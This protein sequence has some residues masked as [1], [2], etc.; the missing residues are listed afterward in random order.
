MLVCVCAGLKSL[1]YANHVSTHELPFDFTFMCSLNQIFKGT[2]VQQFNQSKRVTL[3]VIFPIVSEEMYP[4]SSDQIFFI[5]HFHM[6]HKSNPNSL[7]VQLCYNSSKHRDVPP[8]SLC[9]CNELS[10][11]PFS[12]TTLS[13]LGSRRCWI[14]WCFNIKYF[15]ILKY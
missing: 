10:I 3:R 4:I 13:A 5:Y 1:S 12:N 8:F 7:S 9:N 2:F 14:N 15:N 6:D 11:Y